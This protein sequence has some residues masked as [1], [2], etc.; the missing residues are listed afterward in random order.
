MTSC[1]KNF[2]AYLVLFL[3]AVPLS[4]QADT[5][6][7]PGDYPTIQGAVD[8]AAPGDTVLV[9]CDGSVYV[10]NVTV[11]KPLTLSWEQ[12]DSWSNSV[13]YGPLRPIIDGNGNHQPVI[14]INNTQNVSII[15][16]RIRNSSD[17]GIRAA[18]VSNLLI[19]DCII[20]DNSTGIVF[21]V[22]SDPPYE[23]V[24]DATVFNNIIQ[25]NSYGIDCWFNINNGGDIIIR[26]NTVSESTG[27]G[28]YTLGCGDFATYYLEDNDFFGNGTCGIVVDSQCT[29]VF[30]RRNRIYGNAGSGISVNYSGFTHI[31]NNLIVDNANGV[32]FARYDDEYGCGSCHIAC[33][34][35]EE[36]SEAI[37]AN[38][39]DFY[40]TLI[41]NTIVHN[42]CCG[43]EYRT[44]DEGLDPGVKN[45]I[46]AYNG[47]Y[48]IAVE[49]SFTTFTVTHND[50]FQN[51][52]GNYGGT[53]SD[54]TG[55]NGNI[56]ANPLF[57]NNV[58]DISGNYHP[59]S[60][61]P[62]ID[63]GDPDPTYNDHDGTRNDM[64]A[65]GGPN[66]SPIMG[67]SNDY[68]GGPRLL[69]LW[70]DHGRAEIMASYP[71]SD[72]QWMGRANPYNGGVW[73]HSASN[74]IAF[75]DSGGEIT[76][77]G[78]FGGASLSVD[79]Q[80]GSC[81]VADGYADR[82]AKCRLDGTMPVDLALDGL[83]DVEVVKTDGTVAV[84]SERWP[85]PAKV[86]FYTA[87]GVEITSA[88]LGTSRSVNL[89]VNQYENTL[90]FS[91][92]RVHSKLSLVDLGTVLVTYPDSGYY[93]GSTFLCNP[94]DGSLWDMQY[95]E[96][97][98]AWYK[99]S[100][101]HQLQ[102]A[103]E[104]Q[105]YLL[106]CPGEGGDSDLDPSDGYLVGGGWEWLEDTQD[107]AM[108]RICILEP[109]RGEIVSSIERSALYDGWVSLLRDRV[110]ITDSDGDNLP[111]VLESDI[112]TNPNEADSDFD[113][114]SDYEEVYWDGNPAY[115]PYDPVTNPTGKDTDA[116]EEDTDG[117]GWTDG[118]E[119][120]ASRN[121]L[122]PGDN[123]NVY[124][125]SAST[126][127]DETGN[128]SGVNPWATIQYAVDEVTGTQT[129][130]V[131]IRVAAGSYDEH[132]ILG[133][134]ENLYGGY[135][136]SDW[137]RDI[138]AN[139][140]V[141]RS[142]GLAVNNLKPV[143]IDGFS[144]ANS[145]GF[146]SDVPTIRQCT[147]LE[148]SYGIDLMASTGL[149]S[150]CSFYGT[151]GIYGSA[152]TTITDCEFFGVGSGT[153]I[154][155]MYGVVSNCR[156]SGYETG[157]NENE[158]TGG[159]IESTTITNCGTAV[160]FH[161]ESLIL[162]TLENCLLYKNVIGGRFT[163][164]D[165]TRVDI[166]NCTVVENSEYGLRVG[167]AL[168][169]VEE[170]ITDCILWDNGDDLVNCTATY[171][172]ISDGD[173]GEG[174]ISADPLF[175][176]PGDDDY[177]LASGSPCIDMGTDT[178]LTED[179]E[180]DPRPVDGNMSGTAEYDMGADEFNN[181]PYG[182]LGGVSLTNIFGW[183]YDPDAG[184]S[185]IDAQIYFDGPSGSGTLAA[186][187]TANVYRP[188]VPVNVPSVQGDYHGFSWDPSGFITS[189]GYAPGSVHPVYV[190]LVNEPSGTNPLLGTGSITVP[191]NYPPYGS[192]G[193]VSLTN[194]FGWGYD[195]DAGTSPIDV[196][197]YFDG[198]AGS[199]TLA[200]TVTA[201][202]YRPD[203]PINVPSVQGDYH[204]F[205]WDPSGFIESQEYTP[206]SVHPVYVYLVNQPA[207]T[208]PLLGTGSI[209]VPSNY[210]PYGSLGGVSLTS[211]FGWGYDPDAGTSPI[212]VQ[213]YFDGP[214]GSG[215]YAA[216]VTANI[217]RPDVPINIPSVQ[218]DYHGF[219]WD[220][221]GF[222]ASQSYAPGS[223]HPV[224][225]YLVNQ[226][227]G[228][229]PLLGTAS[230]TIP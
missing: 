71:V 166:L 34:P 227:A 202:M 171:S 164:M 213:I 23:G 25:R 53:L 29:D 15:G 87:D 18:A 177:H 91:Q 65:Y 207:G 44:F 98:S 95:A 60:G 209:T 101:D 75:D 183:G 119:A 108:N 126:G 83:T 26:H 20:E 30:I 140:T 110:T 62:C 223:V 94:L 38:S 199:G 111:D 146:N 86:T 141:I 162:A 104:M 19:R 89:C 55:V 48:G 179:F 136:P 31:E 96:E 22:A 5:I 103:Y 39:S 125:V 206:G 114:L 21:E 105:L 2:L 138:Q 190:Y 180:G 88:T 218:G 14:S 189:Q 41:N 37:P 187:V 73:I 169:P 193:G 10:E 201:N 27:D 117:D 214:A 72:F 173:P 139:E 92:S 195:P 196:Q 220:P 212:D 85:D 80:D 200:A 109:E 63:S 197:I 64:G 99:Y 222:I 24:S 8:A 194:I 32:H 40:G 178:G 28:F 43:L 149:I 93:Y 147:F 168:G 217:Y 182:S 1:K 70:V 185:P 50:V 203:V 198:P 107:W 145:L 90:W 176:D 115:D 226:P 68:D 11:S 144:V 76:R 49:G 35:G 184:T 215:T 153:A 17:R 154:D 181:E 46:F 127:S 174:N 59:G 211:I 124:Y 134:Y 33:G 84:A 116:N 155:L 61:S 54:Q 192:L 131:D 79:P 229:N 188:D 216:T 51:T 159:Y 225:V 221:S 74:V 175:L 172:N 121:P 58:G 186:T 118:E 158:G 13:L 152:G 122:D 123:P 205:D 129:N 151:S 157:I 128:G 12:D 150:G 6:Y 66:R 165:E 112:G 204:G 167:S 9:V 106:Y 230:I 148:G 219:D 210:P 78:G 69:S 142:C 81:W 47:R 113:G 161:P 97:D 133:E 42:T 67:W 132:V 82:L 16:F 191:S 52:C 224:Y 156:I 228:T 102:M 100:N 120:G 4:L 7:V 208:N 170:T 57:I 137:S 77:F 143:T 130:P 36:N 3:I 56:S 163:S 160:Y 135:D 45:N